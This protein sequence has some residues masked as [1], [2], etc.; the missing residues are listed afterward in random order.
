MPAA[1][2]DIRFLRVMR[3]VVAIAFV[4]GGSVWAV[5]ATLKN[6]VVP[7]FDTSGRMVH[8]IKAETAT[9]AVSAISQLKKGSIEFFEVSSSGNAP[10]ATLDFNEA[11][12]DR[13]AQIVEGGEHVALRSPKG[14]VA[15]EGFHYDIARSRLVLKSAVTV[16]HNGV[17]LAGNS[18]EI[19]LAQAPS[20]KDA[21]I[22]VATLK[23]GIVVSGKLDPNLEVDKIESDRAVYT[24]TDEIITVSS[25]VYIWRNGVKTPAESDS[26]TIYVGK[27]PR[28]AAKMK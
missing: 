2:H 5:E 14:D 13:S 27:G 11:I 21:L 7:E 23:G 19:I 28:P 17:H 15:G 10:V 6:M 1:A 3:R 9:G 22:K 26:I 20:A 12:Y 18:A 25:P 16:D 4:L 24:A 8:R